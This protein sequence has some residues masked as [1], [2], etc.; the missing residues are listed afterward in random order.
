MNNITFRSNDFVKFEIKDP[1]QNKRFDFRIPKGQICIEKPLPDGFKSGLVSVISS[2]NEN[3]KF[4]LIPGRLG[5]SS[6]SPDQIEEKISKGETISL[7][8]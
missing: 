5:Y 1:V 3:I 2:M 7:V 4:G 6:L 8:G